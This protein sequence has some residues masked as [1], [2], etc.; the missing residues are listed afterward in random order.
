MS[1]GLVKFYRPVVEKKMLRRWVM[2]WCRTANLT[3]WPG[4]LR[5]TRTNPRRSAVHNPGKPSFLR[6][7]RYIRDKIYRY[8]LV[9]TK[10]DNALVI[11]P[12]FSTDDWKGKW[13]PKNCA[14]RRNGEGISIRLLLVAIAVL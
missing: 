1:K 5:S 13:R 6:L 4:V 12:H 7:D 3:W 8:C 10:P 14:S 11:G 9:S 2:K